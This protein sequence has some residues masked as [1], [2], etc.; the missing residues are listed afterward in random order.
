MKNYMPLNSFGFSLR[1]KAL[2]FHLQN[3]T[4]EFNF[5]EMKNPNSQLSINYFRLLT[6][7][8][9]QMTPPTHTIIQVKKRMTR[10]RSRWFRYTPERSIWHS[11]IR[12]R[13]GVQLSFQMPMPRRHVHGQLQWLTSIVKRSCTEK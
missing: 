1:L 11:K 4:I 3:L 13:E 5:K 7:V 2:R 6:P 10:Q 8:R 9:I 12:G